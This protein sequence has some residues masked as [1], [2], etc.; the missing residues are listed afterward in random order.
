MIPLRGK[1]EG[2]KKKRKK[3]F[4]EKRNHGDLSIYEERKKSKTTRG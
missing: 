4:L 3:F 1:D 2:I